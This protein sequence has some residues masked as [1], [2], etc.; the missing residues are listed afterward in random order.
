[1]I[2]PEGVYPPLG[3]RI[4]LD[5]REVHQASLEMLE[6]IERAHMDPK[7]ALAGM[8]LSIGRLCSPELMDDDTEINL[9]KHMVEYVQMWF[10]QGTPN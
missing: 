3:H 2:D 6:A 7:L 1:V 5:Y 8:V 9:I 4:T 10:I